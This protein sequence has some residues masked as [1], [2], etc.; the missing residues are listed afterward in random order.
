MII[1]ELSPPVI[2]QGDSTVEEVSEGFIYICV[3]TGIPAP[4]IIWTAIDESNDL[5]TPLD[6]TNSPE[7]ITIDITLGTDM[8]ESALEIAQ[9]SVYS[10]PTCIATNPNGTDSLSEFMEIGIQ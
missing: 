7:G 4:D 10:M 6:S 3:A 5:D 1:V 8:V 9:G 2:D